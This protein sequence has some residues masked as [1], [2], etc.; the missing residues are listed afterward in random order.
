L[1]NMN[2]SSR[3]LSNIPAPLFGWFWDSASSV[4]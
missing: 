2:V 3:L 4:R 1:S